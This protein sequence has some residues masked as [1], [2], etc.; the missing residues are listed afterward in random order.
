VSVRARAIVPKNLP[1]AAITPRSS[2]LIHAPPML[3]R[4][5]GPKDQKA[6]DCHALRDHGRSVLCTLGSVLLATL[7]LEPLRLNLGLRL[8]KHPCVTLHGWR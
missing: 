2:H 3:R 4:F 6:P 5:C 8:L 1:W 7:E